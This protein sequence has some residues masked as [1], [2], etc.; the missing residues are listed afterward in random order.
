M[1]YLLVLQASPQRL[2][3]E[4]FVIA[5]AGGTASGKTTVCN[6][7][8][9]RLHDQVVAMLPQDA[10]YRD[11]TPAE[12]EQA[13]LGSTLPFTTYYPTAVTFA[14]SRTFTAMYL[15]LWFAIRLKGQGHTG[16]PP[17]E[18]DLTCRLQL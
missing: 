15:R 18:K 9:Q 11:L 3:S 7:I 17:D 8:M 16:H 5:V 4:A 1:N 13:K 10:F 6:L 14:T 2:Q 12:H